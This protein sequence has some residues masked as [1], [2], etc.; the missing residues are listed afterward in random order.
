MAYDDF[1][2]TARAD[3]S[4]SSGKRFWFGVADGFFRRWPL[5]MLP[6]LLL[7]GLG[8]VQARSVTAQYRSVGTLNVSTNPL[9]ST[10]PLGNTGAYGFET[11]STATTRMIN[12]QL[13]T[14][15]FVKSV[16]EGAGLKSA[17]DQ[18]L[19]TINDVRSRVHASSAGDRLLT[20]S[21]SWPDARTANQ[22][23]NATI[24]AYT[25][26][27]L[28]VETS[29]S[30]EAEKYWTDLANGYKQ[31]VA[32]AQQKVEDY[33]IANPAP[34]IGERPTE[35]TLALS[36]LTAAVT[37]AQTQVQNAESK[38]EDAKL[39]TQQATSQTTEG[40]QVVDA[41]EVPTAPVAKHRAQALVVAVYLFLGLLL[42]VLMLF[43][44]TLLDRAVRSAEDIDTATGLGVVATVPSIA[45]LSRRVEKQI[46]RNELGLTP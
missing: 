5:Y 23:V 36:Y 14:D 20:I 40:L 43:V 10:T 24:Q 1:I 22:L 46:S 4:K 12:E 30:S 2:V 18:H 16:A 11:P 17:L 6:L 8:L 35:Q 39:N 44:S 28:D 34:K 37:Q 3:R 33:V 41:A 19:V 21:A 31:D 38:I 42:V 29:Q 7:V 25:D 45:A 32:T 9:L 13:R 15:V 27:V 26:H